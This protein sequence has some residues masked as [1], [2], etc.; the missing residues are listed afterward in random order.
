MGKLG[1][2]ELNYLCDVDVIWVHDGG[3]LDGH[4]AMPYRP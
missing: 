2:R 1:A 3:G 4:T